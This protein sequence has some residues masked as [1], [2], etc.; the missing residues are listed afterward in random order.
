MITNQFPPEMLPTREIQLMKALSACA[1]VCY[2]FNLTQNKIIGTPVQILDGTTYNILES[3]ELPANCSYT[4]FIDQW[5]SKLP[6]KAKQK[7]D[8]FFSIEHLLE[9]YR[10]DEHQVSH[11]Y[12]TKDVLGNPMLAE[13]NIFLYED[14]TSGDVLGLTYV[15]D[16]KTIDTLLYK[17][18]HDDLTGL[19]SRGAF[20]AFAIDI[21]E[22]KAVMDSAL[23]LI[24]LDYFKTINDTYGHAKGDQALK[25]VSKLLCEHFRSTDHVARIGGDEF[26]VLFAK[27]HANNAQRIIQTIDNINF[28]LKD[29]EIDVPF[30]LSAGL[31]FFH[32]G[33]RFLDLYE[34]AD[35]ALYYKK[36]Q[37]RGGC[38]IESEI[39]SE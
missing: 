8:H 34:R 7:Y 32:P 19:L 26:A 10:N 14:I 30:T 17:S 2:D 22:N 29:N 20:E 9:C 6:T 5:G 11:K 23:M 12:W 36:E 3:F 15:K 21:I 24:D 13:Q 31:A 18:Q 16:L 39:P 35:K 38:S 33:D 25:L 37:G 4:T 1:G 27:L 28:S